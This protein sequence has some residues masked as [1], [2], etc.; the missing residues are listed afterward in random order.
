MHQRSGKIGISKLKDKDR[1]AEMIPNISEVEKSRV[2]RPGTFYSF[3]DIQNFDIFQKI[4]ILIESHL[5]FQCSF[6][7]SPDCPQ[8]QYKT[9]SRLRRRVA[10]IFQNVPNFLH[11]L[12]NLSFDLL[13]FLFEHKFRVRN[14]KVI[15]R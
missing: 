9:F 3:F 8:L 6:V 4:R 11:S 5:S 2:E 15:V 13:L 10:C 1:I 7:V 12:L 14:F